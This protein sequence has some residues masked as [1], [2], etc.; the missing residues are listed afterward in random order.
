[1]LVKL[2]ENGANPEPFRA[3][4]L[5]PIEHRVGKRE[6]NSS[7]VHAKNTPLLVRTWRRRLSAGSPSAKP[8]RAES[9]KVVF[10]FCQ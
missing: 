1:V 3:R 7:P 9:A 4:T 5:A 6:K 10:H 2:M 8:T